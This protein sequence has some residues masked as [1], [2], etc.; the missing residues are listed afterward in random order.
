MKSPL[1]TELRKIVG[2]DNV[3]DD[4]LVLKLYTRSAANLEGS[5]AAVVYPRSTEDVS[6]IVKYCYR[7]NVKIY[8]QGAASELVG[9]STPSA[10]GIVLSFERMNRVRELSIVDSYVVVEPGMRLF[11]LNQYLAK[12]GYMF[13]VDPASLKSVTVGGAINSDS[14]GMMGAKYGTMKNW[15]LELELVLPDENGTVFHVG[16]RTMKY[17]GGYDLVR[18]VVG[19]E[20]TLALVTAATL[21]IAPLPENIVTIG[22]FFP[23]I[24]D[25]METVTDVKRMGIDVLIMEFLDDKTVDTACKTMSLKIKGSG[26]YLLTSV[27][28]PPE[29]AERTLSMLEKIYRSHNVGQVFKAKHQSEAESMGLFDIRRALYPLAIKLANESKKDP[30]EKILVEIEDIS[31]PP[32]RLVEAINRLRELEQKSSVPMVLGGHVGDGNIHPI[33]WV[34]ESDK[35]KLE[36]FHDLLKEIRKVGTELGGTMSSEHGVGLKKKERLVMELES[37]KSLRSIEFMREIK[38]LFDPKGILNPGKML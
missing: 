24:K 32:T 25:L 12:H 20:G 1:V 11:E 10:D 5:A 4:E 38:R 3:V 36:Q 26:H 33:I 8:P 2:S 17:R 9:S 15:V 21:R 16:S 18:L 7:N 13:P 35:E 27:A 28:G 22:G 23:D 34:S 31:V 37:K 29:A 19:S 6:N 30:T 14:G